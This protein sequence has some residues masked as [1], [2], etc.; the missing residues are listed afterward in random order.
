MNIKRYPVSYIGRLR[1]GSDG[2]GIRTL[3]LV[4]DCPLRCKFCANKF[5]WDGSEK[6]KLLS[7]E[8]IYERIKIDRPYMMAT[9]GGI[10]I[11]GGEPMLYPDLIAE[12][13]EQ[14]HEE[15]NICIETSLHVPYDNLEKILKYVDSFVVDIKSMDSNIYHEYTGGDLNLAFSNLKKVIE[16]KGSDSVVVRIPIIPRIT[17]EA[18]QNISRDEL[19]KIGVTKFD[20]FTY[21]TDV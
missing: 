8:E 2:T 19:K 15:M 6:H 12:M 18:S 11:G 16:H 4:K 20:L 10:T 13:Y 5:T 17:D 1:M 14:C 3:V 21:F 9:N 7:A